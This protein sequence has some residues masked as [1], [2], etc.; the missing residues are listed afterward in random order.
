M[1]TRGTRDVVKPEPP[2]S[3]A[4]DRKAA[5][6]MEIQRALKFYRCSLEATVVFGPGGVQ[7]INEV[8]PLP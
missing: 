2:K 4:A 5:C 8:I 1:A 7:R 3:D 6:E